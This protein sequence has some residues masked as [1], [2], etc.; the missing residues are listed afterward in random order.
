[1]KIV[2]EALVRTLLFLLLLTLTLFGAAGRWDIPEFWAYVGSIAAVSALSLAILDPDLMRERMRPGGR[3]VGLRF[4]PMMILLFAHWA[5]AG[6]DRGRLHLTDSVPL[7]VEI[8]GLFGFSLAW[9]LLL[10][11]MHVNR[12]FSSIPR[13]QSERGHSVITRGP[14]RLV[15]HPGYAAGLVAAGSSGIALG[16]WISTA[17][18]PIAI[19]LLIRRTLVEERLLNRELPGYRE[20]AARVR[21]RLIPGIW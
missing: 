16:S 2:V 9:L 17:F 10:W 3:H 20:Y 13:I 5:I 1:M 8:A 21:Y 15:R 7:G 14:Y 11:S 12:F 6:L 19:A 18:A 4:V